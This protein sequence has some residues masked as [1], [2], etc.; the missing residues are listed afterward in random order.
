MGK[1]DC[2]S[3]PGLG[4]WF[5]SNDHRPPHLHAEKT[6]KWGVTVRFLRPPGEMISVEWGKG[7]TGKERKAL[8]QLAEEHRQLHTLS[9]SKRKTQPK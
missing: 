3:L 9:E 7:P 8:T 5:N 2:I 4:L 6:D 1:I